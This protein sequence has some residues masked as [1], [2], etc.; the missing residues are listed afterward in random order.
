MV[1][2]KQEL[3]CKYW[4]THSSARSFACTDHSFACFGLLASRVLL[5]A[6]SFA[7]S[8]TLLTPSLM[9]KLIMKWLFCLC[10]FFIFDHSAL[11][12]NPGKYLAAWIRKP[13]K[14]RWKAA[15]QFGQVSAPSLSKFNRQRTTLQARQSLRPEHG[16]KANSYE[17]RFANG[18]WVAMGCHTSDVNLWMFRVPVK[19]RYS[20]F[21]ETGQNYALYKSSLFCQHINN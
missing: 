11:A 21:Q 8:L 14:E 9:G 13:F 20:V 5:G 16:Q 1:W 12:S 19:P 17:R 15:L 10:F 7:R 18:R 3:R 6:H 2:N 4:A